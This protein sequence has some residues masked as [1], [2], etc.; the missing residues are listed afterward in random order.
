MYPNNPSQKMS[1]RWPWL[2]AQFP[3]TAYFTY[4]N[5]AATCPI[6][7]SV[8]GALAAYAHELSWQGEA[9]WSGWLL[10]VEEVRQ[11]VARFIN[12]QPEEIAFT[13]N[14]S[15]GINL[16]AELLGRDGAV[17]SNTL[18]F[19]AG[20][21]PWL[22]RGVPMQFVK[23]KIGV[24]D[25]EDFAT[26]EALQTQTIV[27]SQVQFS[28]GCRQNL[29]HFAAIK[30]HR[31]LIVCGSQ[32]VGAFGIDV[33]RDG[34]DALVTSGHKW[35]CAGFG[36][37]FVY[38]KKSILQQKLPQSIGWLSVENPFLF[39]NR[40]VPRLLDSNKR[41]ELGC[42]S[43]APIFA[44]GAA[45]DLISS[46]GISAIEERVLALNTYL[47]DCLQREG[48]TVLS[49]LGEHRSGETLCII[50]EPTKAAAFLREQRIL[51]TEKPQGI[52]IS[53]HFFNN[54]EDIHKLIAA[55]KQYQSDA[56]Q[57]YVEV[58]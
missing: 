58:F 19:P 25:P 10:R 7:K 57:N 44:L 46:I 17:L 50:Y 31:N 41:S 22:Y 14:T 33:Q 49:P 26:H 29:S 32:S 45:I 18:E 43:F 15:T 38:I 37:G 3:A 56:R 20:T 24:L 8:A 11:K 42:P 6:P 48:F 34:V 1:E 47:T 53:T 54:E 39:E 4:L 27:L 55:L 28:N 30:Q 23:D 35:L 9:A 21:L 12:A 2:R 13:Q 40:W 36:A 51:V 16:L 52:R 5:A